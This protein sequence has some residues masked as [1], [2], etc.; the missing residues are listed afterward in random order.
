[1]FAHVRGKENS[2]DLDKIIRKVY[3]IR[4]ESELSSL[5]ARWSLAI[6]L[7]MWHI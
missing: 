7:G 3:S 6:P 4:L 2:S 1:M 5:K